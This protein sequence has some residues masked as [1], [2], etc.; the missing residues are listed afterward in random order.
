VGQVNI[1]EATYAL[2]K[3]LVAAGSLGLLAV[4][5]F[6]RAQSEPA[7]LPIDTTALAFSKLTINDGLSQGMVS[8][9]AQ[10]RHGFMWFGTKDGLNRYDGYRFTVFRHDAADTNS[11]RESTI[12]GLRCDRH[13]RLWVGTTT[14]LDLFDERTERFIHLPIRA[15]RGDWG[16]VVHI[17]LDDN[18]DL[19]VSTTWTLVKLTFHKPFTGFDVPAFTTTWFGDGYATISRTRD[20]QLW[21]NFK[22]V[23]F[24]I[25]PKHGTPDPMWWTRSAGSTSATPRSISV[26]STV[27]EDTMRDKL[28]GIYENGIA[29]VDPGTGRDHRT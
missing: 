27:V 4:P 19:W 16:S 7:P 25:T 29:E 3:D 8:T 13:G 14:G 1:S 15:P 26:R 18:G 20:G 9:I 28:Y 17:V 2:V 23:T 24:R 11:V 6:V 10:D 12:T 21:G 5:T 22:E